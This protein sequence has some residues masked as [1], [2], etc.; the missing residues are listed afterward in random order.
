MEFFALDPWDGERLDIHFGTLMALIANVNRDPEK[1]PT[2]FAAS[3]FVPDWLADP[4]ARKERSARD[5][6][7][8]ADAWIALAKQQAKKAAK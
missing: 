4:E 3:D 1:R 5:L 8:A 7:G 6:A 2:P